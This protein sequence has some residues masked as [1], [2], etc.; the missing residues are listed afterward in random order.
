MP[1]GEVAEIVLSRDGALAYAL[2]TAGEVRI[3]DLATMTVREVLAYD[4]IRMVDESSGRPFGP[5]R[6]TERLSHQVH[7]NS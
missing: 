5:H 6:L 4:A 2:N 1:V 7:G 3:I